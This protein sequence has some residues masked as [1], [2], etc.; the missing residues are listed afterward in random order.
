MGF[1]VALSQRAWAWALYSY[2]CGRI[3]GQSPDEPHFINYAMSQ[4]SVVSIAPVARKNFLLGAECAFWYILVIFYLAFCSVLCSVPKLFSVFCSVLCS[5]EQTEHECSEHE[6]SVFFHHWS[7]LLLEFRIWYENKNRVEMSRFRTVQSDFSNDFSH[8][9]CN[10]S[11][12]RSRKWRR[13]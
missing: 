13:N 8:Y 3:F 5:T 6:C 9:K 7:E 12:Y 2:Y 1:V 4:R 11:S 10:I